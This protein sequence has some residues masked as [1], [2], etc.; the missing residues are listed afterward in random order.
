MTREGLLLLRWLLMQGKIE[1]PVQ[2]IR[3]I[4]LEGQN[5]QLEIAVQHG[6]IGREREQGG[7]N[8]TF[9]VVNPQYLPVL[10]RLL[11]ELLKS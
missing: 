2:F 6:I 8:R 7:R 5:R 4:S 11:P 1:C 9:Y 10:K 3:E